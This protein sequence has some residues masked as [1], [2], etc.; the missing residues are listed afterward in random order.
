MEDKEDKS[1]TAEGL[2]RVMK[3][4]IENVDSVMFNK[5]ITSFCGLRAVG[6]T[7][8]F[9]INMPTDRFV[10]AAGIES[11]GLSSAPAIAEYIV[12][13]LKNAGMELEKDPSFNP[14]RPAAHAFREASLEE[15]NEIIKKDPSYGRIICRCETVSEGEMRLALRQNPPANDVDGIKRRTRGGM[16]RCQGGFCMPVVM[17]L[18]SEERGIP[19]EEVTKNGSGSYMVA[20]RIGSNGKA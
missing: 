9:I 2:G 8:D 4:A 18:I 15:K 13:L 1:T 16:G 3:E 19:M 17:R 6:S 11:P 10:N 5:T 14:I 12:E 7:G 20:E